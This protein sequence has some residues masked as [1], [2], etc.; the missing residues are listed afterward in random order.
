MRAIYRLPL[1]QTHG[2]IQGIFAL[3]GLE[4]P[5]PCYST[6]CRRSEDLEIQLPRTEEPLNLVV[7]STGLK[8]Y[9]EGEWKVRNHGAGKRRTWRK[10]HLSVNPK[11]H[12]IISSV[13]TT[14]D[15]HDSQVVKELVGG[16]KSVQSVAADGAY[17]TENCYKEI[18]AIKANPL[19]PPRR[20]AKISQHGNCKA[21]PLPR[22]EN[23]R[24][25]RKNGRVHWKVES[26]YHMRSIAE[27][28]MFRIKT[29][30]GGRLQSRIFENQATEALLRC[31]IMNLMTAMGMPKTAVLH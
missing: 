25:I 13:I 15:V 4:L 16:E 18:S 8:I 22:D 30:F 17:D 3:S 26:G 31:K 27:T 6:L 5:V 23:I 9:G 7:D 21:P 28:A 29:I 14:N 11:T 19:I 1:R 24:A 20:G 2:F 12:E 10:L